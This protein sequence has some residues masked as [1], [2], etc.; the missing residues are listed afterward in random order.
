MIRCLIID[1]EPFA[2]KIILEY[3]KYLPQL[4]VLGEC[5][6]ALEARTALQE[7]PA[8]IIFLDIHMPVMDGFGFLKTL[9]QPPQVI[10]TTAYKEY[11]ANAF[12]VNACDYLIKPF[13]LE[14]F[15]VA[16]DKATK[17][18]ETTAGAGNLPAPDYFFL[19]T[20][21][22]IHKLFFNEVLYAEA[23]GNYTKIVTTGQ[24]LMPKMTF[25]E[26]EELLPATVFARIHRSFIINLSKIRVIEGNTVYLDKYQLP[27]GSNY[28]ESL[29]K[30][31]KLTT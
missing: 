31:L 3:C 11:A 30:I 9:P 22:R 6:N 29:L 5:A 4:Q 13:T 2:R 1:D 16:I 18:L 7:Q 17:Q 20:D 24:Q 8:D 19:K 23:N 10:F 15:I 14:R 28:K 26:Y 25:S 27:I 21:G 12:D